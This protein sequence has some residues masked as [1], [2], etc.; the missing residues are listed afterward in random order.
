MATEVAARGPTVGLRKNEFQLLKAH[1]LADSFDF[2][3]V[4]CR[5]DRLTD[6]FHRPLS[7]LIA[8]S[9]DRLVAMLSRDGLRSYVLEVV[10]QQLRRKGIDWSTPEGRAAFASALRFL[11]LRLYRGSGKSTVATHANVLWR[12]TRDPNETIAIVSASDD[13]AYAFSNQIIETILSDTYRAFFPERVPTRRIKEE[14]TQQRIYLEGRTISSPQACIEA[15]GYNSSWVSKHYGT[16]FVDDLVVRENS[17]LAHLKGVMQF[18]ASM[19]GLYM[20]TAIERKHIGTVW[21]EEDDGRILERD[22]NFL[23]IKV[24]IEVHEEP[25]ENIRERGIPTNPQWHDAA[26]ITELQNSILSDEMEGPVSWRANFLLDPGAGNARIFPASVVDRSFCEVRVSQADG[27]RY[28][29]RKRR[30]AQGRPVKDKEG[31]EEWYSV[32]FDRLRYV[33]G[34]DQSYSDDGDEWAVYVMGEDDEGDDYLVDGRY[35]HGRHAFQDAVLALDQIWRP[36]EIGM[37]KAAQQEASIEF[38]KEGRLRRLRSKIKAVSHNNIAKEI[39]IRNNLAERMKMH[40]LHLV[41][42]NLRARTLTEPNEPVL[43]FAEEAKSYKPGKR[44]KDNKLDAAALASVRVR[45]SLGTDGD[46][47]E[48]ARWKLRARRHSASF[49][50]ETGVPIS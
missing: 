41:P 50:P 29:V 40:K 42:Y 21:D 19:P 14:L 13:N 32:R 12:A 33:I 45:R 20:P 22:K 26:A 27:R 34:C 6:E 3:R 1:L 2:G 24:P 48:R 9:V 35:G 47:D 8:G 38:M 10:R 37:E 15:R 44:A 25:P 49:D 18:L 30:D 39:R 17:S 16:F 28:L 46:Q 36:V 43:A 23:T 5:H 7:Y 11:N 4:V 31:K